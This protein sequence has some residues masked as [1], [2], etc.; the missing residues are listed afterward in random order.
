MIEPADFA[1]FQRF[2]A[3]RAGLNLWPEKTYLLESRLARI[4]RAHNIDTFAA[5]AARIATGGDLALER[6]V[7]EAM[8]THET[9][10]FRDLKSFDL[11]R[12]TVLPGLIAAR[13]RERRLAIWSAACSA[14]QEPYSIAMILDEMGDRLAGWS[15]RI[16]AT[17]IST[18]IIER[19]KTG[20]YTQFEVQRG[21]PVRMLLKHFSQTP[22]GWSI[23]KNMRD[24]ID[25]R[26]FN[27][28]RDP[29][30]FGVFDLILCRNVLIYFDANTRTG[31]FARLRRQMAPDGALMLGGAETVLG[32]TADFVPD[33]DT[34]SFYRPAPAATTAT[35]RLSVAG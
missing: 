11:L 35:P 23:T 25:F 33:R 1:F 34:P 4:L 20:L 28:L 22:E 7:I 6:E 26:T 13:A 31:L 19:A 16:L 9:L 27:L 17:D 21:L 18:A 29:S 24:K 30:P 14:G 8:M 10:F 3:E 5:L 15:I 32:A 2:L 12:E